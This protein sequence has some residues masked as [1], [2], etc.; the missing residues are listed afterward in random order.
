MIRY[1]VKNKKI[2]EFLLQFMDEGE[3]E[4][5]ISKSFFDDDDFVEFYIE[6]DYINF[7][8]DYF[9]AEYVE[10]L[11]PFAKEQGWIPYPKFK[12]Q[13]AGKLYLVSMIEDIVIIAN[14]DG[15]GWSNFKDSNILAF[16]ELPQPFQSPENDQ[17][18][19]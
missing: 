11:P 12:P 7:S 3:I 16:R 2:H 18:T 13:T 19:E 6:K 4:N 15:C 8:K 5:T 9:A 1:T 10:D 14:W 17:L